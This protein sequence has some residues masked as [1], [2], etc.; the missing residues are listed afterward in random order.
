MLH[1]PPPPQRD[2]RGRFSGGFDGG[3]RPQP[4]QPEPHDET[5][6]RLA[7]ESRLHRGTTFQT[8]L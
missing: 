8:N 3:A 6:V 4:R 7:L 1:G 2:E 5:V